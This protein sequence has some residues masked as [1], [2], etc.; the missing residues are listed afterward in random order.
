MTPIDHAKAWNA[1]SD[2]EKVEWLARGVMEWQKEVDDEDGYPWWVDKN[3]RMTDCMT[4]N[5]LTDWNHWRQVEQEVMEDGKLHCKFIEAVVD[6]Y[7]G[8]GP[9]GIVDENMKTDLSTRARALYLAY[10]SLR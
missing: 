4:W 5:P 3:G 10:Q 7:R 1:M 2:A 9:R 6:V 8:R